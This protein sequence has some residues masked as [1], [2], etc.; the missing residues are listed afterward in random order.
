MGRQRADGKTHRWTDAETDTQTE[1]RTKAERGKET[2][3]NTIPYY[4][5]VL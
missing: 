3:S 5:L 2:E 4:Q 1:S